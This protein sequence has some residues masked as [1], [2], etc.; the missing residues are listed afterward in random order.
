MSPVNIIDEVSAERVRAHV[1]HITTEIP[2]RLAGSENAKRMAQYSAAALTKAGVAAQIIE[3]PGLVS[4]PDRAEMRVLSPVEIAIEANTL[5]HSVPTLADGIAGELL[6]V[7]SGAFQ[8][9]D[10]KDATGKI[11]LSELSYH[12]ARHE[13]QRISGL[14]GASGCVMMNWGHAGNTAVPF[15]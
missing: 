15:G 8:E 7:A 2:S 13:K 14:M 5:G 6:D 12:P 4:F 11:T 3:M 9:Y 10:G 1:E